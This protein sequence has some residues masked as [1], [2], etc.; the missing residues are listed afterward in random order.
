MS[1][2][3][4]DRWILLWLNRARLAMIIFPI[5]KLGGKMMT[6]CVNFKFTVQTWWWNMLINQK[7]KLFHTCKSHY[8]HV[9]KHIFLGCSTVKEP[10][11]YW[12]SHMF[13]PNGVFLVYACCSHFCTNCPTWFALLPLKVFQIHLCFCL[14]P[15]QIIVFFCVISPIC[16]DELKS[17]QIKMCLFL[18]RKKVHCKWRWNHVRSCVSLSTLQGKLPLTLDATQVPG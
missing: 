13:C 10:L 14:W 7:C 9:T 16:L 3:G 4:D 18:Q 8:I 2:R 1:F 5:S 17:N 15:L 12:C 11:L 6:P